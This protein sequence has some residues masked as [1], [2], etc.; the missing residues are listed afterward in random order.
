MPSTRGRSLSWRP[1]LGQGKKEGPADAG[2]C[3]M[4]LKAPYQPL[5][6]L[7]D[8]PL[9]EEPDEE[10]PEELLGGA[11]LAPELLPEDWLE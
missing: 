4:A 1:R 9:D 5:D 11:E 3:P 2:P 7:P 10:L 6:E 8:D